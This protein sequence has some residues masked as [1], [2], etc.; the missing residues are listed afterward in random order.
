MGGRLGAVRAVARAELR[1]GWRGLLAL[2]LLFGLVGGMVLGAV[3]LA[4][5]TA[6]AYPRLVQA[7]GL[8]DA[9]VLVPTD[10]PELAAAVPTLPGVAQARLV[11]TWVARIEG[12]A[13]RFVSVGAG[14]ADPPDLVRPVVVE[15][16]EPAPDSLDEL[17]LSE[18]I[19]AMTGLGVGSE[20]T[21]KMLTLREI[22]MFDVGFGEPDGP[23]VRMRVVGVGRMPEWS[24][25]LCNML[26]SP[27][28]AQRYA[29]D[30]GAI[31]AFVR[32]RDE[33]GAA[34]SFTDA[35]VA[36]ST[37]ADARSPSIAAQYLK[38][39]VDLPSATIDPAVTAAENVLV[40]GLVVFAAVLALGGLQ[41]VGQGLTRL[42][43]SRRNTQEVEFALGMAAVERVGSRV[44]AALGGAVAGGVVGGGLVIAAGW[45]E[46]LGS[47]ARFEPAMGFRPQWD[48]AVL[49]G[50]VL[51]A[52]F[53]LLVA[54]AVAL[55]GSRKRR[56]PQPARPPAAV[57]WG[58]RWP[59]LLVG[60]RLALHGRRGTQGVPAAAAVVAASLAVAGVVAALAF[61]ASLQRLVDT[62][63]RYGQAAD[64]QL[65]DA[66]EP[67]LARLVADPRVS[68]LDVS[69]SGHV[70]ISGGPMVEAT[71]R[72][73]RKGAIPVATLQGHEP[74]LR[75]EIALGPRLADRLQL[76][77]GDSIEFD[78]PAG[79]TV[80]LVVTGIMVTRSEERGGLGDGVVVTRD[81]LSEL[82][83]GPP[84]I[85][86]GIQAVPG[87]AGL[88]FAELSRDLEIFERETPDGVRNLADLLMLPELLALVLAAV[89]GSG[90]IHSLVTAARRHARDVAV[91]SVLGATPGQVRATLAVMA[92]ATVVPALVVGVPLG[93]GAARVLW[94]QVATAT[95]VAGDVAV[96]PRLLWIVPAVL[97]GA[98]LLSVVPAGRAARTPPAVALQG[99]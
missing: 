98:L 28:F 48:L 5:R 23:E 43:G 1:T 50:S 91:L 20:V 73:P 64:L 17:L 83:Q 59:A 93:L 81:Q 18:P 65:T 72:E 47:Q 90:M 84:L 53:L 55:A 95:G 13:L 7:V 10:Q 36:A 80:R 94:W 67:D 19:A 15:G 27:A 35:F 70:Q 75:G 56:R 6:T 29:A 44:L 14:P 71:A 39:F 76:I 26:T 96:P 79:G 30:A 54:I 42:H 37:A 32:L 40:I 22:S 66:R 69:A 2:G 74:L 46:P 68:A 24:G 87:Q 25:A 60:V 99:R 8:D 9:R 89:A 31:G 82:V 88:L 97:F 51:V 49:G 58:R 45:L 77:P 3:A 57:T 16:R 38:P 86:A 92:G 34:Q 33:P 78:R 21:V 12:P 52:V 63:A 11:H 61:G 4:E 85:Y 41:V 62:P